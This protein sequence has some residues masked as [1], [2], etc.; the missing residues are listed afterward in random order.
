MINGLVVV[1]AML[2]WISSPYHQ[3]DAAWVAMIGLSLLLATNLLDRETFR[4]GINWDFLFYLGAVLSLTSVVRQLGI[5]S[6]LINQLTPLLAPLTARPALFLLV[7]AAAIFAARFILPSF[8]LVSLLTI[9]VVPIAMNAGINALVLLL[10]I[11]MSVTVWF[12]P[13]QSTCYLALYFGAKEQAFSHAQTRKLAWSYGLIYLIATLVAIPY[14]W[15]LGL[16][17]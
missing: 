10:I 3:I 9:T 5:D 6:W 4:A 13:Y 17:P 7:L 12:L 8:P 2:G 11:C 14:W 1:A 15:M 16:L